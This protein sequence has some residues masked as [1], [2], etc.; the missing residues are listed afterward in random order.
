MSYL[1]N[2]LNAFKSNLTSSSNK[3]SNKRTVAV[4]K[5]P[6]PTPTPSQASVPSKH[7]LKRKRQEPANIV[8]SQPADTGTGRSLMTQVTYAVEYLK[9]KGTPQTL[10]DVLSYLSLQYTDAGYRRNISQ[11]LR[12]HDK[13]NYGPSHSGGEGL[14]S[15]RPI[16]N[17]RSSEQL[18]GHLQAQKTA[19]GI[20]VRELRDGWADAEAA[21]NTLEKQGKLLVTRNKKDNHP[22]MVWS[23]DPSLAISIDDEFKNIWNKIRLPEPGALADELEKEGLTPTNK[24]RGVKAKNKVVEKKTKKPRKSGKT[25]NTHMNGI[26]RDYSHLKK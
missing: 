24:A 21:I 22:K 7:D 17:I 1:D 5:K 12:S 16:H 6:A 15:Y 19:Q 10:S 8:Y 20:N 3:I 9:N 26:L 2:Q 14:F 11:I 23:N 13:V 25:T 18:L 4:A